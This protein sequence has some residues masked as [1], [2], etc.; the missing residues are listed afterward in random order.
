M[1]FREDKHNLTYTREWKTRREREVWKWK[2]GLKTKTWPKVGCKPNE[3]FFNLFYLSLAHCLHRHTSECSLFHREENSSVHL[4]WKT[5][6]FQTN[7]RWVKYTNETS[8]QQRYRRYILFHGTVI[9][10]NILPEILTFQP[11]IPSSQSQAELMSPDFIF[12][13]GGGCI[14]LLTTNNN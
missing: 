8:C 7:M 13:W 3:M 9:S 11:R 1:S 2:I 5:E 14:M 12:F 4:W 6:G 10:S